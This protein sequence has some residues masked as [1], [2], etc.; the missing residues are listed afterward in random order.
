M[1]AIDDQI[2]QLANSLQVSGSAFNDLLAGLVQVNNAN[3]AAANSTLKNVNLRTIENEL[4]QKRE[5]RE[6]ALINAMSTFGSSL[7]RTISGLG[8]FTAQLYSSTTAFDSA[9]ISL[10]AFSDLFKTVTKVI[11]DSL[12]PFQKLFG[13]GQVFKNIA[14]AGADIAINA[15]KNRIEQARIITDV[16]QSVGKAGAT[17][18]GSLG[19]LT[20]AAGKSGINLQEFGRFV[21]G[22]LQNL[23]GFGQTVS[24]SSSAIARL[25]MQVAENDRALLALKGSYGELAA[26][27]AEYMA[28]QRQV[29]ITERTENKQTVDSVRNYIRLQNELSEIT[30]R[31]VAEQRRAEEQR[32][33]VAA[34]QMAA[35]KLEGDQR[36][37]LMAVMALFD[38]MGPDMVSAMQEF[39]SNEGQMINAQNI[40]FATMNKELF[41]MGVAMLGTIKQPTEQF[42][43][44]MASTAASFVPAIRAQQGAL[45]QAGF[46][47][48]SGSRV[49]GDV[50]AMLG[51]TTA[52]MIPFLNNIEKLPEIIAKLTAEGGRSVG[53][54]TTKTLADAIKTQNDMKKLLDELA[55]KNIEK[56]PD[57][58]KATGLIAEKLIKAE[59]GVSEF[60]NLFI[61]PD[62]GL[63]DAMKRFKTTMENTIRTMFGDG[64]R[65]G[66]EGPLTRNNLIQ[67]TDEQL[68]ARRDALNQQM[69][70]IREKQED[71]TRTLQQDNSEA[72]QDVAN[73]LIRQL[74]DELFRVR[75]ELGPIERQIAAR[76]PT[77]GRQEGGIATEPTIVGENNQPE[78][79]IPLARGSI[80][81]NINFDPMLRI[82][83]QQRE[84]L[85]E[86]LSA[87]EDNSDYLERIYHATA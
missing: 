12:G 49:G 81:L 76:G 55:L 4:L 17:F 61:T 44:S 39:F 63:I 21:S 56:L 80:P 87:T 24:Q 9:K 86:I 5:E 28:L 31:S 59:M 23:V 18:G 46:L 32:R 62:T 74:T 71:I 15:L 29:G 30:G 65:P 54:S 11:A 22:N 77:G 14:D 84:Y 40:T 67:A 20:E 51:R 45:D 34:Y 13:V 73:R 10:D 60:V 8:S 37:N 2:Q 42:K 69:I 48:L 68:A 64:A 16:F 57:I 38:Q 83:E 27:A 75:T 70:Q 33:Q 82:L 66:V 58:I 72:N 7:T 41:D 6:R 25:G 43:T 47:Q 78:A 1:A 35:S 36:N 79:V 19:V 50:V 53:D 52:S 3:Q 26:S 85:E